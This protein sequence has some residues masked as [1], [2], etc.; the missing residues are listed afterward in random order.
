MGTCCGAPP[1]DQGRGKNDVVPIPG[2]GTLKRK[3]TV[4]FHKDTV[5]KHED[6][7]EDFMQKNFDRLAE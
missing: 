6:E 3:K 7:E 2:D 1:A 4:N 5:D